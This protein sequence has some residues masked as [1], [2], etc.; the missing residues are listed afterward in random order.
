MYVICINTY[1]DIHTHTHFSVKQ[2]TDI[3]HTLKHY[4]TGKI[5]HIAQ[6]VCSS[7]F[8]AHLPTFCS[9]LACYRE[10][11]LFLPSLW[12]SLEKRE[13]IHLK[14]KLSFSCIF[15][16]AK[17]FQEMGFSSFLFSPSRIKWWLNLELH[18]AVFKALC[19]LLFTVTAEIPLLQMRRETE[20]GRRKGKEIIKMST[21]S[22]VSILWEL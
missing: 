12:S 16:S 19:Y 8:A 18:L 10:S 4:F 13:H 14:L 1:A 2:Q 22:A 9:W 5:W 20:A 7:R 21:V 17:T 15:I 11:V 3:G 6:E